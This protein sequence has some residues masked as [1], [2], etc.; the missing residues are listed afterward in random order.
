MKREEF[1]APREQRKRGSRVRGAGKGDHPHA[2][3][4]ASLILDKELQGKKKLSRSRRKLQ[5]QTQG[6]RN[7]FDKGRKMEMSCGRGKNN[8]IT[9]QMENLR[10]GESVPVLRPGPKG[11]RKIT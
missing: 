8:G 3:A 2:T 9:V 4:S 11:G 6:G 5:Q 7:K 1:S 10:R